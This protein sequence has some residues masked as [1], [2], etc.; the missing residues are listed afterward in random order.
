MEDY[1]Y[2]RKEA[3]RE[4]KITSPD[5]LEFLKEKDKNATLFNL[6]LLIETGKNTKR[7]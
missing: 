3:R 1:F 4:K 5:M 7:N 6:I 2:E